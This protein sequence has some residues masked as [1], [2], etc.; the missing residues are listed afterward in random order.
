M[1]KVDD[2]VDSNGG[3]IKEH[4]NIVKKKGKQ[5]KVEYSDNVTSY[6]VGV[7]FVNE[8]QMIKLLI[9]RNPFEISILEDR[10]LGRVKGVRIKRVGLV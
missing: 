2:E 3:R 8:E 9:L 4:W 6:L 10:V 5:R 1:P 7:R